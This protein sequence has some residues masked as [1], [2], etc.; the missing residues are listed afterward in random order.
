VL[1]CPDPNNI[2]TAYIPAGTINELARKVLLILYWA[3]IQ[4]DLIIC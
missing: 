3:R 2:L 1:F 4:Q